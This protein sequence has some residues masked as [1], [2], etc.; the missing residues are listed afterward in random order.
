VQAVPEIYGCVQVKGHCQPARTHPSPHVVIGDTRIAAFPV[1]LDH[2]PD[3]LNPRRWTTYRYWVP[4]KRRS[5]KHSSSK[6]SGHP[7]RRSTR[8]SA[9]EDVDLLGDAEAALA[10]D[11]PLHML[12]LA[13]GLL[14]LLDPRNDDPF[15]RS[16]R[17]ERP[18]LAEVLTALVTSQDLAAA[19]VAWTVA[20]LSGDDL[21]RARVARD[22]DAR[23]FLLPS[24]MHQ[25]NKIEI[26]AAEQITD[27]VRDGYNIVVH[28]RLAG[29][30]L[31]TITFIDFN[32]G[33][34]VKDNFLSDRGL[35]DFNELW[36]EHAD[37]RHTALEALSPADARARISASIERGARTIPRAESEDWPATRPLLEWVVRQLPEG[38]TGFVRPEWSE[39]DRERL[40]DR[41]LASSYG[42]GLDLPEDRSIVG[43]LIFYRADYGYGDPLHWSPTAIEIL[44]MDWYLRKIVADQ[45]YLRQM[46]TVLRAFVQFVHAEL[47]LDQELT[48]EA[49]DAIDFYQ[50]GYLEAI[51][52]PRRQGPEA[53]LEA[54]GVLDPLDDDLADDDDPDDDLIDED[55]IKFFVLDM[56]AD[57]VGGPNQLAGLTAEQL[58]DEAFD[59]DGLPEEIHQRVAEVL[60]LCDQC[61]DQ[62]FD[63]EH[64]TAVRRLLHDVAAT[65]RRIFMRRAKSETAAAALCWMVAR[66]NDSISYL[67][68]QTQELMSGFGLESPP[69]SRAETMRQAIGAD[70]TQWP[71]SLGSPRYLT[72]A[73]RQWIIA[74]RDEAYEPV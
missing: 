3:A 65:D 2:F 40:A 26:V 38:G 47:G 14:N 48:A 69:S 51:G 45:D 21:L 9:E 5:T 58:P 55:D 20:Q 23:S 17:P 71:G 63:G 18:P 32:M 57:L 30:D 7:S 60:L 43:D 34:I 36:R 13:S 42:A 46:P 16:P 10:A 67:K 28:V 19:A 54:A 72:G 52:Q 39:E 50:D 29:H 35:D 49:L 12:L 11:H 61:C 53:I 62:Y 4:K 74:R 8:H 15:D 6:R 68:L 73:R 24:W 33:I 1:D 56:L 64:R 22:L 59:W 44:M 31:T 66:A 41:F 37:T 70:R 27:S 25:L